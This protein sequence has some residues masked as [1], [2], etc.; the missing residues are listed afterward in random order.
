MAAAYARHICGI[1]TS[2]FCKRLIFN[3]YYGCLISM[4][5]QNFL[6]DQWLGLP[7]RHLA[8]ILSTESVRKWTSVGMS[9]L[10]KNEACISF[11]K[12]IKHLDAL[13]RPRAHR[14]PQFMCKDRWLDS[15]T[16]LAVHKATPA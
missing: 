14:F 10:P 4:Q 6:T 15:R 13:Q 2:R 3:A 7:R 5:K 1:T 16:G 8:T 11:V 9:W 12:A